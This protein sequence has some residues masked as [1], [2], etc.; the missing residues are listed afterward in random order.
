M[1]LFQSWTQW[2][3]LLYRWQQGCE[4]VTRWSVFDEDRCLLCHKHIDLIVLPRGVCARRAA[5][6]WCAALIVY[7]M[8]QVSLHLFTH[9]LSNMDYA[10]ANETKVDPWVLA[11]GRPASGACVCVGQ[12]ECEALVDKFVIQAKRP[13]AGNF[14]SVE[15]AHLP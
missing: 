2:V 14:S 1:S 11:E 12:D 5:L 10:A 7:Q 3:K 8:T 13:Q 6:G 9:C 15:S 4:M